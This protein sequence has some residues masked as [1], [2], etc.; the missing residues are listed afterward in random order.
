MNSLTYLSFGA[1]VSQ[2]LA[3]AGR[4]GHNK[5]MLKQSTDFAELGIDTT[6]CGPEISETDMLVL[7]QCESTGNTE[8]DCKEVGDRMLC[9]ILAGL[10][11]I[12]IETTDFDFSDSGVTTTGCGP[13]FTDEEYAQLDQCMETNFNVPSYTACSE[14]SARQACIFEETLNDL[15]WDNDWEDWE[16]S[17]TG[18]GSTIANCGH[19]PNF[20]DLEFVYQCFYDSGSLTGATDCEEYAE[21]YN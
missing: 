12:E 8:G 2:A 20:S 9:H 5:P 21:L 17:S 10:S 1:I 16:D 4:K 13:E 18:G 3:F 11:D 19:I 6:N 14:L 15:D 7:E